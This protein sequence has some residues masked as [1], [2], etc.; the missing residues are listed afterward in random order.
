[1]HASSKMRAPA[2]CASIE[3]HG[4]HARRPE[5]LLERRR[6]YKA[7]E[8]LFV[9]NYSIKGGTQGVG[10]RAEEENGKIVVQHPVPLWTLVS[11]VDHTAHRCGWHTALVVALTAL[12][13]TPRCVRAH[14]LLNRRRRRHRNSDTGVLMRSPP[15]QALI[16]WSCQS[17]R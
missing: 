7:E 17:A 5:A 10:L 13:H 11:L 12:T 14:A 6:I 16:F 9:F 3:F 4:E 8:N 2:F 1:M 15:I